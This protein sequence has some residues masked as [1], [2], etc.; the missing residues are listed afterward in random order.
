MA[1][2]P[3]I[4]RILVPYDFGE[5]AEAAL[6]YALALVEKLGARV[7][8]LHVYEVPTY[9]YAE[10]MAV[11]VEFAAEIQRRAV[12][13]LEKIARQARRPSVEL[14]TKVERGHAWM[15]IVD[16]AEQLPADL[17]VMGTHG[18]KGMPRLFLGSVAEKVVR[19]GPC[20]VLTV[21]AAPRS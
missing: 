10:M 6:A 7:T 15:T 16:A 17:I 19:S 14:D 9:G 4:Q 13:S 11:A 21:H 5:P 18:R 1:S 3:K 12:E 8:L 2:T 20:P